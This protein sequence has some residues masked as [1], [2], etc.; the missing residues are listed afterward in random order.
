MVSRFRLCSAI[1]SAS[2][3]ASATVVMASTSTAS[4][5]PMIN[6]DV[7]G[8][9]P[10]G[11]PKGFGRSPTIA[12]PGAVKM[13]TLSVFE[14]TGA[15]TRVV[16]FSP[17]VASILRSLRC[18][19]EW[20]FKTT[21]AEA[22]RRIHWTNVSIDTEVLVGRCGQERASL[23]PNGRRSICGKCYEEV[24]GSDSF[25]WFSARPNTSC[26]LFLQQAREAAN[27]HPR[28]KV[29]SLNIRCAEVQRIRRSRKNC[30]LRSDAIACAVTAITALA[31]KS[32][33][34]PM[35]LVSPKRWAT[36]PGSEERFARKPNACH[37]PIQARSD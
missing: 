4:C 10:S 2:A 25:C 13:F 24:D 34:E 11:S 5:S 31:C 8:S 29:Q 30:S 19:S 21:L 23:Y 12:F 20:P 14:A 16:S 35:T 27:L 32:G 3:S 28:R 6:V 1:Q 26:L 18:Q 33:A 37:E 7:A 15:V 17:F 36:N 9:K 22:R